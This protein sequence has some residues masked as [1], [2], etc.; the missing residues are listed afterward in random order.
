MFVASRVLAGDKGRSAQMEHFSKGTWVVIADSERALI[1]ENTGTASSPALTLVAVETAA[2]LLEQ[3]DRS[4]R[5]RDH[6]QTLTTEPPDYDRL[7]GER[8]AADV[9]Q[10]LGRHARAGAF[11]RLV[12][13][14]PPQVLSAFR[15]RMDDNLRQR[16]IAEL[17][18]TLTQHP[19]PKLAGLLGVALAEV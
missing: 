6:K 3:S 15:A 5:K 17:H 2:D 12:I 8:L 13:A 16:V 19:L 14:A 18:K 10:K 9:V 1:L 4:A 7:A 11:E